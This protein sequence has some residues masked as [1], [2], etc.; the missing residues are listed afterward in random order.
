MPAGKEILSRIALEV[1]NRAVQDYIRPTKNR[2]GRENREDARKFLSGEGGYRKA[3]AN[4]CGAAGVSV[5]ALQ[6]THK[7]GKYKEGEE[8]GRT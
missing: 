3:L 8:D 6:K 5:E 7:L 2:E 1:I 4:W